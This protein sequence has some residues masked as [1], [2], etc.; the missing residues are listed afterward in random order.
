MSYL[1]LTE[2]KEYPKNQPIIWHILINF[3]HP[4][5]KKFYSVVNLPLLVWIF[6]LVLSPKTMSYTS[7]HEKAK[8]SREW[9]KIASVVRCCCDFISIITYYINSVYYLVW[10]LF[11]WEA[12]SLVGF[13]AAVLNMPFWFPPMISIGA[14]SDKC[15]NPFVIYAFLRLRNVQA[16]WN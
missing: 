1:T 4:S 5:A 6:R 10:F 7:N 12:C 8:N 16:Y 9:A 14:L 3:L 11:C 2:W 13:C 15:I